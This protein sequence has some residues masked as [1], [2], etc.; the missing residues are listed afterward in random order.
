MRPIACLTL[1][2][3]LFATSALAASKKQRVGTLARLATPGRFAHLAELAKDATPPE[4]GSKRRS[5]NRS[6]NTQTVRIP[7]GR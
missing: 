6:A 1:A 2:L 7:I 5:E 3:A 4:I